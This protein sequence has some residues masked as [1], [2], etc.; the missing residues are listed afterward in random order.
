MNKKFFNA[1]TRDIVN[2]TCCQGLSIDTFYFTPPPSHQ[3]RTDVATEKVSIS[4]DLHPPPHPE[5]PLF[6]CFF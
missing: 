5:V 1:K 2:F 4:I 3:K 6:P